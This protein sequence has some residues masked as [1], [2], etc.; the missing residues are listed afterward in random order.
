MH[1]VPKSLEQQL[2]D[3]QQT[4]RELQAMLIARDSELATS[5]KMTQHFSDLATAKAAEATTLEAENRELKAG[6]SRLAA[7]YDER[8]VV[9]AEI[10]RL[11]DGGAVRS[12]N[13]VPLSPFAGFVKPFLERAARTIQKTDDGVR[14][15][16]TVDKPGD[17]L[18]PPPMMPHGPTLNSAEKEASLTALLAFQL[19][20]GA[21]DDDTA[22]WYAN[23]FRSDAADS[24]LANQRQGGLI[25]EGQEIEARI[26]LKRWR[27]SRRFV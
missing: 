17:Y 13:E 5:R 11:L 19:R 3:S 26:H 14:H 23:H 15:S 24:V 8:G 18:D 4:I 20:S 7:I 27:E 12:A 2:A 1:T 22:K 16:F 10:R 6:Q 25:C 21:I 9:H